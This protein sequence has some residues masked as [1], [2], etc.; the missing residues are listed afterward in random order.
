MSNSKVTVNEKQWKSFCKT[1][2]GISKQCNDAVINDGVIR[3]RSNDSSAIVE[4]DMTSMLG[5]STF[6]IANIKEELN[7]LKG[8]TG[9]VTIETDQQKVVFS[10][11]VSSYNMP[12]PDKNYLDNKYMSKEDLDSLLPNLS[13][14][15]TPLI[16]YTIE[17]KN[18]KRIK[19][20]AS[21]FHA[22]SY[23]VVFD[24]HSASIIVEGYGGS[25]GSKPSVDIFKDIPLSEPTTGNTRLV[26]SPYDS[27]DYDGDVGWEVYRG[28]KGFLSK[29]YG[30]IGDVTVST[31]TRGELK[32]D[33]PEPAPQAEESPEGG[34]ETSETE[35]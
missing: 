15:T 18:L 27:F 5:S 31:Y 32:N 33:E 22:N 24:N 3:Q 8:L 1:L 17:K 25:K 6:S 2:Q 16:K 14:G 12:A 34:V 10:D 28:E 9:Q 11:G 7:R 4:V 30:S 29:N 26:V 35:G 13:Q 20:A 19:N 23:K 21:T